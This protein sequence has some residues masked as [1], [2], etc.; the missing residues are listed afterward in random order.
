MMLSSLFTAFVAGVVLGGYLMR[1]FGLQE[2]E[3]EQE[4]E[5]QE[6]EQAVPPII[7]MMEQPPPPPLDPAKRALIYA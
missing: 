1:R 2:Q 4:Q 3:Q 7:V 5:E 6:Q